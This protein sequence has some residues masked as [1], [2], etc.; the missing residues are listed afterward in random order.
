MGSPVHD[1]KLCNHSRASIRERR[2]IN[3][4]GPGIDLVFGYHVGSS[5][6]SSS[7]IKIQGCWRLEVLKSGSREMEWL[8][9]NRAGYILLPL[10]IRWVSHSRN[11]SKW[12]HNAYPGQL[13]K[14][15]QDL[16][17]PS[18]HHWHR[19]LVLRLHNLILRRFAND[20]LSGLAGIEAASNFENWTLAL[21]KTSKL[22][23]GNPLLVRNLYYCMQWQFI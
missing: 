20:W 22:F 18:G 10:L 11:A 9:C 4:L 8:E 5:I 6:N 17:G 23:R 3:F 7:S 14:G 13:E 2:S 16:G 1:S 21:F 12:Q 15:G 19:R